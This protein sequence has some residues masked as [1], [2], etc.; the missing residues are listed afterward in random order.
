MLT[1]TPDP[2][3][4]GILSGLLF[5]LLAC[6]ALTVIGGLYVA[7]NVRVQ[8]TR[9]NGGSEDFMIETPGGRLDIRTHENVDPVAA[10]I[11]VYPGATR[12]K[13]SGG[14]TFQWSSA[15]GTRDKGVALSGVSL[16]TTDP[17]SRVLDYYKTQLPNWLIVTDRDGF[18]HLEFKKSGFKRIIAIEP[19]DGGTHIGIA[20]IGEP[21]SN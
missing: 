4:G 7:R 1:F 21:A 18:V 2:R 20:S 8:T 5:S 13:D 14:A 17:S 19:K 12:I 6:V 3:R 15:D 11:P 16:F 10:G 9:H